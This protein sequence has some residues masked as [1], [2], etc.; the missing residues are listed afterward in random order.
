MVNKGVVFI[1]DVSGNLST[2]N[3]SGQLRVEAAVSIP[4]V[5]ADVSGNTVYLPND[6]VNNVVSISGQTVVASVNVAANVSGNTIYIANDS[7]NNVVKVSGQ[8]VLISGQTVQ[9]AGGIN[10]SGSPV[11]VS[12]ETIYFIDDS[13]SN[14][15]KISGQLV[16]V[17]G[18]V[19]V[20]SLPVIS[21]SGS[22]VR[23]T[24]DGVNNVVSISGQ[25][26]AGNFSASI[27]G[28]PVL[29]SGQTVV[30]SV[31]TNISG[32]HVSISGT[33][34][35][36]S[37]SVI[38]VSGQMVRLTNDGATNRVVLSDMDADTAEILGS[39]NSDGEPTVYDSL[40]TAAFNYGYNPHA[41]DWNRLRTTHS[42]DGLRLIVSISGQ[43]VQGSFTASISGQPVLISGQTVVA[44]VSLGTTP[45]SG[46]AAR[47]SGQVIY[48]IDDSVNNRVKIS[49][50]LVA[51]SGIVTVN[52]LPVVSVSGNALQISG[53]TVSLTPGT[54][55]V[56]GEAVRISGSVIYLIDDS[57]N[58][59]VKISGQ[60]VAVSG[61]ININNASLAVTL[62][63][64]AT[65]GDAARVSGQVIYLI[66]D[67][68]NNKTKISGQLVAVSGIVN[69]G[70]NLTIATLPVIS[71]S[72]NLVA[73]SGSIAVNSL[74]AVSVSG[75]A[76]RL[77][78]DSVNNVVRI[79][80]ETVVA[81]VV[82]NISGQVVAV[83]GSTI[84]FIDNGINN[85]VKISGQTVVANVTTNIS[86][87]TIRLPND[88][89]NNV[90]S[91]SGQTVVASVS[92]G[93]TPTSGDAARVSGQT[94]YF[95]DD[96]INNKVK[97]SGQLVAVSG[98]VA[99]N[100]LP[101]ISISGNMVSIS[102]QPVTANVTTNI[103]GQHVSVSG[104]VV[105]LSGSVTNI[106]GQLILV[107]GAVSISQAG[108][109]AQVRTG[110]GN[111]DIF[112]PTTDALVVVP[113][114]MVY[115]EAANTW[116]RMR[117]TPAA[118]GY[119]LKVSVSGQP[120]QPIVP[121]IGRTRPLLQC[122]S[123]SGGT[124]LL[125]GDVRKATVINAGVSGNVMYVGFTTDPPFS[126][127]GIYLTA[128]NGYTMEIDN[129]NRILAFATISGQL[130]SYGGEQY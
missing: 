92:M 46:D 18:I 116:V 2:I 110:A 62:P 56:S 75:N 79:S 125:S 50:Q 51:V 119:R 114:T 36:L 69:I 7:V 48:L 58:N 39:T 89:V 19:A 59:K 83:S 52:S 84:Y 102:G 9:I 109:L 17:S 8:S 14:K 108:N 72:G 97:I 29:I 100:S 106:S 53:Q 87:Q 37:G 112:S 11:R 15:V 64:V 44:S 88:G 123:L 27:S 40:V 31:T 66:D 128:G 25:T 70:N 28:Q 61:S 4:P 94:I 95:V 22:T 35:I 57:V 86:G 107:S 115:D 104:T 105:T 99:V 16:A 81:N 54:T 12:G 67:S 65:S 41:A 121:T 113:F 101:V 130:L 103:S 93:P 32:Q 129:F 118:D 124:Q 5:S 117:V 6:G 74:P 78:N 71:V 90:V 122:T 13:V 47:V 126:G 98:I 1:G 10:V 96:S 85:V 30:T 111:T 120:V 91:I 68:V 63:A 21:V 127:K 33:A 24:N 38:Q 73:V 3:N 42:G 60:L 43:P 20:N 77:T 34:R 23:L 49:G 82:T 76:I 26:V 55:I 45:T 80:G